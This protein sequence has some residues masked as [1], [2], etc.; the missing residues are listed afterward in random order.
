MSASDYE[1]V[2]YAFDY[3]DFA[4]KRIDQ[5]TVWKQMINRLSSSMKR[6]GVDTIILLGQYGYGKTFILHKLDDILSGKAKVKVPFD[7]DKVVS[8]RINITPSEP[9]PRIGLTFVT[10]IFKNIGRRKL[11]E[12]SKKMELKDFKLLNIEMKRVFNRFQQG[13]EEHKV[14]AF[15]WITGESVSEENKMLNM[16]TGLNES[17][18][19]LRFLSQFLVLLKRTGYHSLVVLVDEF[20]YVVTVYSPRKVNQMMHMF[21]HIYDEF[22]EFKK[23]NVALANLIFVI[24]VTPTGW[25]DLTNLEKPTSIPV[26]SGGAGVRPWLNRVQPIRGRNVFE[27]RPFNRE[28]TEMLVIARL[29]KRREET[30]APYKTF[31]FVTPPFIDLLYEQT[32]GVPKDIIQVCDLVINVA[33]EKGLKEI[34]AENG[35]QILKTYHLFKEQIKAP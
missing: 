15:H 22:A 33:L 20:E 4:V 9:Q 25:D 18:R 13:S 17:D 27:L 21:R 12:I 31:P 3:L 28:E 35:K 14:A 5:D 10:S 30:E 34:N 23:K 11:E 26:K 8:C 24:A 1:N 29:E 16:R 6:E 2:R 7:P 32:K 19:A